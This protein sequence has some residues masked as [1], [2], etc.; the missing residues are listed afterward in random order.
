MALA[1]TSGQVKNDDF[2]LDALPYID[3]AEYDETHREFAMQLI[4]EEQRVYPMTKNYLKKFPKPDYEKFLTQRL[5]NEF[6]R[7]SEKK[8]RSLFRH[9]YNLFDCLGHGQIG[10][11]SLWDPVARSKHPTSQRSKCMGSGN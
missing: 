6:D 10:H 1:I 8:V 3:D 9:F 4:E 7:M 2:I 11:G 5:K